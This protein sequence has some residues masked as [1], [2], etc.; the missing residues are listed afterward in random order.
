MTIITSI[1]TSNNGSVITVTRDI[2]IDNSAATTSIAN[3]ATS[4]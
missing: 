2:A 3:L 4:Q 1:R